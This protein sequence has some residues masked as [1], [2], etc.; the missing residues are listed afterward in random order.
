M[1]SKVTIALF[2]FVFLAI[3]GA[4]VI[5]SNGNPLPET[6]ATGNGG[7]MITAQVTSDVPPLQASSIVLVLAFIFISLYLLYK[8]KEKQWDAFEA[9]SHSYIALLLR[10][11]LGVYLIIAGFDV[12]PGWQG[13]AIGIAKMV[14]G[15]LL[16]VGI[17]VRP[18]AY[19]AFFY[20]LKKLIEPTGDYATIFLL[21]VIA[22]CIFLLGGR[23]YS[24]EA[25]A[26]T[27]KH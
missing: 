5:L 12:M 2:I 19:L 27:A 7:G 25:Q 23:E 14:L 1:A 18:A 11:V 8:I 6:P 21:I 24:V 10:I 13:Y 16:M 9:K 22:I 20:L 17:F 15:V 3:F 4:E 26:K